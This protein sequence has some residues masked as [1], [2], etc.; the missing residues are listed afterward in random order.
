MDKF[1][2]AVITALNKKC[3]IK[4]FYSDIEDKDYGSDCREKLIN[5]ST[6]EHCV[7]FV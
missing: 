3:A 5:F 1:Q 2:S 7:I 4:K 6:T